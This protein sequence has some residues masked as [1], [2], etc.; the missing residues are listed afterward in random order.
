MAKNSKLVFASGKKHTA[1]SMK[2]VSFKNA[3]T[4]KPRKPPATASKA[5]RKAR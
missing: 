5:L 1:S 4:M 2:K 3:Q